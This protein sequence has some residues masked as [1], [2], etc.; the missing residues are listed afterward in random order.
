MKLF[1]DENIDVEYDVNDYELTKKYL[2]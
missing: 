2:S 1:Y